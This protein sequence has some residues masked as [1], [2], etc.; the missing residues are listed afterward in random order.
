MSGSQS[1][2]IGVVGVHV[3]RVAACFVFAVIPTGHLSVWLF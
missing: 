1:D 2:H 3:F